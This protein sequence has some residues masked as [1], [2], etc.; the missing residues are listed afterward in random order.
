VFANTISLLPDLED[1]SLRSVSSLTSKVLAL[2]RCLGALALH[3]RLQ[4]ISHTIDNFTQAAVMFSGIEVKP[5]N[6]GAVEAWAQV[7]ICMAASMHK[8]GLCLG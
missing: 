3:V 6:A 8:G 2:A 1:K 4:N 7:S 5:S